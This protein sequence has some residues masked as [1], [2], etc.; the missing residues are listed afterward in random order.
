MPYTSA[1]MEDLIVPD[2]PTVTPIN[3]KNISAPA[4]LLI[5][6][7]ANKPIVRGIK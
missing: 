6:A 4:I 2:I 5:R 7:K 3:S 1:N